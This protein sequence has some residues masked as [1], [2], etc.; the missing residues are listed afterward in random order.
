MYD[1]RV[2]GIVHMHTPHC[3]AAHNIV[4]AATLSARR[5]ETSN[6]HG[7]GLCSSAGR[8][9]RLGCIVGFA[10]LLPLC[11]QPLDIADPAGTHR[12]FSALRAPVLLHVL[13][14]ARQRDTL[15]RCN[16][17]DVA[18]VCFGN[19]PAQ[20]DTRMQLQPLLTGIRHHLFLSSTAVLYI[21]FQPA[22]RNLIV[23][24]TSC[25]LLQGSSQ[26]TRML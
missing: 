1:S 23:S 2:R 5:I 11:L 15:P 22:R 20:Y 16:G 24:S 10:A 26:V 7:G 19:V 13:L 14:A 8:I 12:R 3:A 25:V 21:A 9:A 4:F 17:V 18:G 6:S